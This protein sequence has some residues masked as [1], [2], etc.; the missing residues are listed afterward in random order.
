MDSWTLCLCVT[1]LL[2]AGRW[3]EHWRVTDC[4]PPPTSPASYPGGSHRNPPLPPYH[5]HRDYD[6]PSRRRTPGDGGIVLYLQM[7]LSLIVVVL[8][9]TCRWRW[10]GRRARRQA[11]RLPVAG[12]CPRVLSQPLL[13]QCW[14]ELTRPSG[15]QSATHWKI[16]YKWS[17]CSGFRFGY[18]N[19]KLT[20]IKGWTWLQG[21]KIWHAK[22]ILIQL[23]KYHA[24]FKI[25]FNFVKYIM[26]LPK[27]GA[28]FRN[29]SCNSGRV[30]IFWEHV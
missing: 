6:F 26:Q 7:L 24:T 22:M 18:W 9:R 4:E 2:V 13:A 3:T 17:I 27:Y 23:T 20:K 5:C 19:G 12:R 30:Y 28:T 14:T 8:C 25:V 10:L 15:M 1:I 29:I 21:C 16:Q 11:G